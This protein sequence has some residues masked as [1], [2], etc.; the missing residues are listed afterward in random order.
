MERYIAAAVFLNSSISYLYFMT[1]A[2]LFIFLI[3]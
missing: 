1:L 3:I 2:K